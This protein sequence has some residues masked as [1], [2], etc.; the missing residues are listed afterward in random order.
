MTISEKL[1]KLRRNAGL[2]QAQ[3]AEVLHVSRAAVAKWENGNGIPDVAN[4]KALAEYFQIS[5]DILLDEDKTLD[6]S[7]KTER[8]DFSHY[9]ATTQRQNVYDTVVVDKFPEAHSIYPV[10]LYYHLNRGERIANI[11][12][13]GL[14]KSIW[15]ATHWKEYIGIYYLADT[16]D[17]QYLVEID[18]ENTIIIR[19]PYRTRTITGT[20][21]EGDRKFLIQGYDLMK[22][23]SE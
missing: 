14:Y 17:G 7:R 11:L 18:G 22:Q 5:I 1:Q 19:L 15:Q 9:S 21:F 23:V 3:L 16:E 8:I 12:T 20:F 13:L 6:F 2:S 10:S 4:L